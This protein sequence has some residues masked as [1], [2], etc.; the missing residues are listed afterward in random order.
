MSQTI[1]IKI[2]T[3][4]EK[5]NALQEDI[6]KLSQPLKILFE[7]DTLQIDNFV[8]NTLN[9]VEAN[10]PKA[11]TIVKEG[12]N[13]LFEEIF[14]EGK[15]V[16]S[17]LSGMATRKGND[18]VKVVG[19]ST[20]QMYSLAMA[21]PATALYGVTPA[22]Q[23]I[24]VIQE[25][26][27]NKTLTWSGVI[28]DH[29]HKAVISVGDSLETKWIKPLTAG[30]TSVKGIFGVFFHFEKKML[31]IFV[32]G[33][34]MM[35]A[36]KATFIPIFSGLP[37]LFTMF[38]RLK[39]NSYFFK[40]AKTF[41]GR[42]I[43]IGPSVLSPL[44]RIQRIIV[45]ID[46][47]LH[48]SHYL[49]GAMAKTALTGLSA[50]FGP[51]AGIISKLA[52]A[53]TIVS[54]FG[55]MIQPRVLAVQAFF[56][57]AQAKIRLIIVDAREI[58]YTLMENFKNKS[59]E[60]LSYLE[61]FKSAFDTKKTKEFSKEVNGL[62]SVKFPIAQQIQIILA[63]FRPFLTAITQQII[64]LVEYIKQ[65]TRLTQKDISQIETTSKNTLKSIEASSHKAV[66]FVHNQ[67]N[68]AIM[69]PISLFFFKIKES[70]KNISIPIFS[71]FSKIIS[72]F[73][74][75]A[76][77]TI[78]TPFLG[79]VK[80]G[81]SLVSSVF[82]K[83][84]DGL[85][86]IFTGLTSL[87][88]KAKTV[89]SGVFQKKKDPPIIMGKVTP[90]AMPKEV[91]FMQPAELV[92]KEINQ[93]SEKLKKSGRKISNMIVNGL[94]SDTN[95]IKKGAE[96]VL[97][98]IKDSLPNSPPKIG[99]LKNLSGMGKGIL[100]EISRG[101][102]S[103]T[104]I[105]KNA[106]AK[107]AKAIS[108]FF[109]HSPAEEGAL[110]GLRAWGA[111][112]LDELSFGMSS[113][114][115]NFIKG[116]FELSNKVKETIEPM[117]EMGFIAERTGISIEKFSSLQNALV[118]FNISASD[119][120]TTFI[121]LN[122]S[123]NDISSKEKLLALSNV[124]INLDQARSAID[125]TID[126][127]MQL[128]NALKN[129]PA[130]SIPM[131]RALDVIGLSM[132]TNMI[133]ALSL[134]Q[135][136]IENMISESAEL[137]ATYDSTFV[138]VGHSFSETLSKIG[139]L[140]DYLEI[141]FLQPILGSLAKSNQDFLDFYKR[142]AIQIRAAA[143][144]AGEVFNIFLN[145]FNKFLKKAI[146]EPRKAG[147]F[148]L[149][150]V[151]VTWQ[152]LTN[153]LSVLINDFFSNGVSKYIWK[154][155]QHVGGIIVVAPWTY[156]KALFGELRKYIE[157]WW[158]KI[159]ATLLIGLQKFVSNA[160][161]KKGLEW[162]GMEDF[163]KTID[164]SVETATKKAENSIPDIGK[165][166][167]DA[168]KELNIYIKHS[169]AGVADALLGIT[170]P[171]IIGESKARFLQ[172]W[173][174]IKSNFEKIAKENG[175][176][177]IFKEGFEEINKAISS[178]NF[179]KAQ[180]KIQEITK[181]SKGLTT[182][183][184]KMKESSKEIVK[185]SAQLTIE[186][187]KAKI[188]DKERLQN[189]QKLLSLQL[190]IAIRSATNPF[191]KIKAEREKDLEDLKNKQ[192]Q[193]KEEYTN[194]LALEYKET[195]ESS[196]KRK[197]IKDL[198]FLHEK[199]L[200][201]LKISSL[202]EIAEKNMLAIMNIGQTLGQ[203]F[204]N[205]YEMSGQKIKEFFYIEKAVAIATAIMEGTN[206]IIKALNDDTIPSTAVRIANAA[207]IG[208][209]VASQ[210]GIITSQMLGF[211]QGG[212]AKGGRG[213]VDDIPAKLTAGEYVQPVSPVKYYGLEVMESIRNMRIPKNVFNNWK[214]PNITIPKVRAY[215]DGG[216]VAPQVATTQ[217]NEISS[218]IVNFIDPS[219]FEQFLVSNRGQNMVVN[220]ISANGSKVRRNWGVK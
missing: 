91:K 86:N 111:K 40:E 19:Q 151:I 68:S 37:G 23:K 95:I 193:E 203:T 116:F 124:G 10:L 96:T 55:T 44:E 90:P 16:L 112:I 52:F 130:N 32:A 79:L 74:K 77:I 191:E 122:K 192:A 17:Q 201:E 38:T 56:G 46:T 2:E 92:E 217:S 156:I 66:E 103:S 88:S 105:I 26:I 187:E 208:T 113:R 214:T 212:L 43:G 30:F 50:F 174:Q 150:A 126:L 216:F 206:A 75:I 59:K 161:I 168:T 5:F 63:E 123:I 147:Q 198:E 190:D 160:A 148:I 180:E 61:K 185:N 67:L 202:S 210:V 15:E 173:Q 153:I 181:K 11:V 182:E 135:E 41:L 120:Q 60:T 101:M 110:T 73:V 100:L 72:S 172:E 25:G 85:K 3:E 146:D 184:E 62:S 89:I 176:A 204:A 18:L 102:L 139:K 97:Q 28:K 129:F 117:L 159:V 108:R 166:L 54:F 22:L 142:H 213:G 115:G 8:K 175:F 179:D 144:I 149:D 106:T 195:I 35:S 13:Q 197:E 84:W 121:S 125:P 152:S 140:G 93:A 188:I 80:V 200:G 70:L 194:F 183:L 141:E 49:I 165:A 24:S 155:I 119:L 76:G 145:M 14:T 20:G 219:T 118:G 133:N 31:D 65:S 170:D 158:D 7:I 12:F 87:S 143:R 78:V 136:K 171:K 163:V 53:N 45:T 42:L 81:A 157:N 104:Q 4:R 71:L 164:A 57:N 132:Q 169:Q 199:E 207:V 109:P 47:S 114:V 134:G 220:I 205:F 189:T 209:S 154:F 48:G 162:A 128:S 138:K 51:F 186:A 94:T 177:D 218:T 167:L 99:P 33:G 215:A 178:S 39:F 9:A 21:V 83:M 64:T 6:K 1:K 98:P 131:Q 82:P 211:N 58:V 27:K 29:A 107:I 127:Y 34:G 69:S 36:V 137:G 196:K